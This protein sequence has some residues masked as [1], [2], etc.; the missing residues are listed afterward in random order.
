MPRRAA[1]IISLRSLAS[2]A[3]LGSLL[4]ADPETPK[5]QQPHS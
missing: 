3:A 1:V 4:G 2:E 5:L